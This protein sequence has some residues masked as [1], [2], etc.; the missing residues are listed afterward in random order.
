MSGPEPGA[1]K[2]ELRRRLLAWRAGLSAA[3]VAAW[4]GALRLRLLTGFPDA[5]Q[6]TVLLY[7]ALRREPQ[8][9]GLAAELARRGV[10]L[11]V[12]EVR[13]SDLLPRRVGRP[14]AELAGDGAV[15]APEA[16]DAALVPGLAFDRGGG[17]LGRGGGH[18]DRLLPLLRPSCVVIGLCFE[19]QLVEA[20]PRAPWDQPV[21]AVVTEAGVYAGGGRRGVG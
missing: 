5:L 21:G 3:Q 16:I 7:A 14:E 15:L 20:V 2:A 9:A 13:G 10:A 4:S 18:Y 19:G 8:T 6:G 12:P 11:A 1:A 17:R